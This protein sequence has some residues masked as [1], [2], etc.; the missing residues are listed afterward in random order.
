M[1]ATD[2][3]APCAQPN[4]LLPLPGLSLHLPASVPSLWLVP[5]PQK[6]WARGNDVSGTLEELQGG[7]CLGVVH[8]RDK[9]VGIYLPVPSC[10]LFST[11]Q[12]H[13]GSS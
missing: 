1:E 10:L 2:L 12:V 3:H 8:R 11:G 4:Q 7:T 9:E 13:G 6:A 5:L